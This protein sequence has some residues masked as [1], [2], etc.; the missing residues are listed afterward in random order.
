MPCTSTSVSLPTP[1]LERI[2]AVAQD[3]RRPL[4]WVVADAVSHYLS[5]VQDMTDDG[6]REVAA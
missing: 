5:E 3:Q 1:L 4:S 2:T 6:H